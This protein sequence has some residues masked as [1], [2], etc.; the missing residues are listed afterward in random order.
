MADAL[1][2]QL[3]AAEAAGS[4][5]ATAT[6]LRSLVCGP[7]PNDAECLKVKEAALAKL[8]EALVTQKDAAG[9]RSLLADLRPLFVAIPK[10]KTAKIVRT[11]IDA[12]SRVPD[13]TQ[14]LVRRGAQ[15][16]AGR[17]RG[18]GAL[19]RQAGGR[20]GWGGWGRC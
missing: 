4:P 7:S 19:P 9:L 14:L 6:A 5:A 1:A 3:A 15:G 13:S 2:A 20:V 12:I 17:S 18:P 11:V 10:A 8:T 16:G